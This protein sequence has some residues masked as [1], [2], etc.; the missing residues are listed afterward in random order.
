MSQFITEDCEEYAKLKLY[1]NV[2]EVVEATLNWNLLMVSSNFVI[3][4]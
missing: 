4:L 1:G 2:A 3:I